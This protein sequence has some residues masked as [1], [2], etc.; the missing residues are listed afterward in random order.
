MVM[1]R[2]AQLRYGL[3]RSRSRSNNLR[4]RRMSQAASSMNTLLPSGHQSA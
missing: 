4:S 3:A 1:R 2:W